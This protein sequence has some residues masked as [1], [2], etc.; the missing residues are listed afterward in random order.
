MIDYY[1]QY[2]QYDMSEEIMNRP[3]QVSSFPR[4]ALILPV[5]ESLSGK[6]KIRIQTILQSDQDNKADAKNP[7]K[8]ENSWGFGFVWAML[9]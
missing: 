9:V 6:P 2:F 3:M 7:M 4:V 1:R 5:D 8:C